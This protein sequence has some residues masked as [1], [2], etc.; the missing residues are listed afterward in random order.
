MDP[1]IITYRPGLD[2]LHIMSSFVAANALICGMSGREVEEQCAVP[3]V[4]D[5]KQWFGGTLQ[6]AGLCL[7]IKTVRPFLWGDIT[8]Y[9]TLSPGFTIHMSLLHRPAHNWAGSAIFTQL[10]LKPKHTQTDQ[11]EYVILVMHGFVGMF[12]YC[13]LLNVYVNGLDVWY[14]SIPLMRT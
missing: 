2:L 4:Y 10:N 1:K 11:G 13:N 5:C 7:P 8:P 14:C 6:W 9:D 3:S 12:L